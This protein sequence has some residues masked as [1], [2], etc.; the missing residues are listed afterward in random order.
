[1]VDEERTREARRAAE[2][3]LVRVAHHYGGRPGFVLIG[4]L[5]P[6]MLCA[7]SGWRHAGTTD[8]DVQV[9]LEI[10]AASTGAA[11]L[12]KALR[13]ADF[14]VD[15]ERA[16]RWTTASAVTGVPTVVKFELLS[17]L[18]DHPAGAEVRFDGCDDLGAANLR[19]TGY[20]ARDV[21]VRTITARDG[22]VRRAVEVSVTGTAGFLLAK[23]AAAHGRSKPKD[24]YDIA[25]VLLHNTDGGPGSAVAAV[26]AV[27]GGCPP[28]LHT[29]V[30]ELSANFADPQAQG[31][32]AYAEQLCLDH[33][34]EDFATVSADAV[35]AVQYFATALLDPG[36]TAWT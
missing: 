6:E 1:M 7:G 21:E 25:F 13:N 15:G 33:P 2:L 5:V 34:G 16:W 19:G 14:V 20:A 10:A 9:D 30:R 36:E 28:G 3:A 26:D 4:G 18:D 22:G 11:R 12:E 35:V 17:D 31:P 24:W 32:T 27:F 29:A 23:T 8:V